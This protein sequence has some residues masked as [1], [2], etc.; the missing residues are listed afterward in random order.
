MSRHID[1]DIDY[2]AGTLRFRAPILSRDSA[3]NPQFIVVDYETNGVGQRVTNAGA[4]ASWTSTDA[5]LRVGATAIHDA[6]NSEETNLGAIDIRYRPDGATEIRAEYAISD[7][8]LRDASAADPAAANAWLVEAEHHGPNID[9]LAYARQ[10]D[11]DFGVGQLSSAGEGTRKFGVDGKLHLGHDVSLIGSAWQEE[12]LARDAR[13]RA[14]RLLAEWRTL[15]TT[16]RAGL[17]HAQDDL[18]TGTVNRSTLLQLGATQ[19][20]FNQRLELDAQ[21]E[22]ALSDQDASVDF[23]ATHRLAARLAVTPDVALVGAYEIANG[24]SVDA[25][26]ARIGFDVRPWDGARITG[27]GNNQ[28]ISEYGPRSF[29]A[30]G[31]SQSIAISEQVS[32][33]ATVDGQRTLNGIRAADVLDVD[34]P[35]ASGGF[36]SGMGTLSEDFVAVTTGATFR[37]DDW[38]L[39]TRGEYR[40]G[41]LANRYGMTIG[42]IRRLGEGRAFG[43]LFTWAKAK[44]TALASTESVT[45]EISWAHRPADSR[46]SF[47][48]KTEM[49]L[50]TVE[51]AVAGE[52]GAAGG[53]ALTVNGTARTHRFI[54][55][56]TINYSPVHQAQDSGLWSEGG[57]YALFV[58]ARW[59]LDAIDQDDVAGWSAIVGAD[60]TFDLSDHVAIGATG[61]VRVGTDARAVAWSAGP[62][63]ILSPMQNANIV[64]G[65]NLAGYADR[66]FEESRYSRAG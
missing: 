62:Q 57:E 9:V 26:T 34:Q 43:G 64:I 56:L 15:T 36:L 44:G 38:S 50:D 13:R 28:T 12:Y 47:L 39:T 54:N 55:S 11:A 40:D 8:H 7:T 6:S 52:A 5:S 49:R 1:S 20:L 46:W 59:N 53:A 4:R 3:L 24:G 65:Y 18:G 42:G 58:G 10:R 30:Y 66:D 16:L 48:N 27:S 31:L 21:T 2:F 23:P 60:F 14:A 51:N 29:A 41:E 19:R 37:N 22:F 33:D 25:R 61:N 63:I 45:A 32:I 35:V 17:V